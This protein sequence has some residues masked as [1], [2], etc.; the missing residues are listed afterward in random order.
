[1][2]RW[3]VPD[4]VAERLRRILGRRFEHASAGEEW[5]RYLAK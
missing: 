4:V 2:R 5:P 1:L 3:G